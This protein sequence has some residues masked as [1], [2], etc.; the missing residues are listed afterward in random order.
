MASSITPSFAG[1]KNIAM[2]VP[3][4]QWASVVS[5]YRDVLGLEVID[6]DPSDSATPSVVFAFGSNHLWIDRVDTIS[7]AELWLELV[8]DDVEAAARHLDLP[9]IARR[10][11]IE[12]LGVDFEGFWISSPASI[13]HLVTKAGQ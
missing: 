10:D 5:F 2:K 13:I 7:Q 8:T 11:E 1:G 12:P 9:G 4:H 3:S 6:H